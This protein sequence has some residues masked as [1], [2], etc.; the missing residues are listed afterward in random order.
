MR[1]AVKNFKNKRLAMV[2]QNDEY[3]KTGLRGAEKE[4]EAQGVTFVAKLAQNVT[5]TEMKPIIMQLK[6]AN[7]EVV[8]LWLSPSPLVRVLA[9]AKAM[10]F[11][12]Q[13]MTTSTC[14]DLPLFWKISRGAIEGIIAGALTLMPDSNNAL[15][16][17]YKREVFDKYA[18]K[19]ERWGVFY[20]AGIVFAEPLVEAL[21]RS[22]RDLTRER[23]V[24]ELEGLKDFQGISG[25]ISYK[26][27]DPNDR[28][29]RLGL[30]SVFIIQCLKDA[31]YNILSDWI[32]LD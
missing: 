19:G 20:Y 27:F 32:V 24:T 1:Y 2:Y 12:P 30:N 26:P 29:S 14:S 16:L 10:Q 31:N 5:E 25:K 6:K 3:G 4:L 11:E 13:W 15:L 28:A 21:H 17:S 7:A 18:K 8:L 22:G 23:L 9:T